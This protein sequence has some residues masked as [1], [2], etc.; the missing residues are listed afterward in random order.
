MEEENYK[1]MNGEEEGI[2]DVKGNKFMSKG[3]VSPVLN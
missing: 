1:N 3:K 2:H